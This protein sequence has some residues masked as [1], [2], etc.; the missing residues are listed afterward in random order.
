MPRRLLIGRFTPLATLGACSGS[1]DA[2]PET[3]GTPPSP[4][5]ATPSTTS[6]TGIPAASTTSTTEPEVAQS[7]GSVAVQR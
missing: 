2:V 6:T 3:T 1:G 4:T 5:A 7:S